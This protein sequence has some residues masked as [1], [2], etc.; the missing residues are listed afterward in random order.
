M[1]YGMAYGVGIKEFYIKVKILCFIS[2][3]V[4]IYLFSAALLLHQQHGG[5]GLRSERSRESLPK[6]KLEAEAKQKRET[7]YQASRSSPRP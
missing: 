5:T 6:T 1:A 7:P 2:C 4:L 3:F